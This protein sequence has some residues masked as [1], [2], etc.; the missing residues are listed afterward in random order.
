MTGFSPN[1]RIQSSALVAVQ[2]AA[3]AFLVLEFR[4]IQLLAVHA[5]RI[6][7]LVKDMYLCAEF[8]RRFKDNS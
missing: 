1:L 5:S 7:I 8:G 6:K 3:E 4:C 2:E